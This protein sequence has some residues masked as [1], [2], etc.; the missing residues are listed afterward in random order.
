MDGVNL[1]KTGIDYIPR[2]IGFFRGII[3][4]LTGALNLPSDSSM[5]IFLVIAFFISY[6]WIKQWITYSVFT[7]VSTILN[8]IL[9]ALLL[10]V[11]LAYV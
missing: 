4:K 5:L 9:L 3:D 8:W 2:I 11:L 1:I 7:K 10:Y 6:F